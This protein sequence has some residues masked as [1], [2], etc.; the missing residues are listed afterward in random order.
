MANLNELEL[1]YLIVGNRIKVAREQANLTQSALAETMNLTRTSLVNI[2][3]GK[4][5]IQLHDLYRA[6]IVLGIGLD[7]LL[8]G[9]NSRALMSQADALVELADGQDKP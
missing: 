4:Q 9:V 6:C 5:R 7:S 2:E 3:A 8:P 1:L